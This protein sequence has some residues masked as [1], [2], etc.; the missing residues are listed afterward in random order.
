MN[1][2]LFAFIAPILWAGCNVIDKFLLTKYFK[3]PFD[4]QLWI[5]I[6]D[7]P[8]VLFLLFFFS[9]SFNYPA[10]IL[11]IILGIMDVTALFIYSKAMLVEEASRV[12]SLSYIQ[13]LFVLPMAYVF[14]GEI[15]KTHNYL[16]VILLTIGAIL[17][18]FKGMKGEKRIISPA[19]KFVLILAFLW[20][21][22]NVLE[23][24]TLGFIEYLSLIMWLVIGHMIGGFPL[25]LIKKIRR[26]IY[27]KI[28]NMNWVIL[29]FSILTVGLGYS[30]LY[31]Y[32]IAMDIGVLSLTVGISLI[33]PFVV[34]LITT[35]ISLF[36]PK[37]IK[38][39]I[40]RSTISLKFIAICLIFVGAW[41]I[42]T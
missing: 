17:I 37:I 16:G 38:E 36:F 2:I 3:N 12:V 19:L 5:V 27:I 35:T 22:M 4:Y 30:A 14:F 25:F 8:L 20:A 11:G 41:L 18:S 40:D 29:I 34:F 28:K 21:S 39:K 32:L 33:S 13:A 6:M 31:F 15:L 1:W 23:K 10:F 26:S 7:I 24:Y 9:I 42:M